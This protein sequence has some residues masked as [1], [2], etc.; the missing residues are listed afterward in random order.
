MTHQPTAVHMVTGGFTRPD[1]VAD[2]VRRLACNRD[3]TGGGQEALERVPVT[4]RLERLHQ[5]GFRGRRAARS[6]GAARPWPAGLP[7]RT[8]RSW[9]IT[10]GT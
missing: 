2:L 9:R 6:I 7:R 10:R 4:L 3:G 1:E 5:D 8:L